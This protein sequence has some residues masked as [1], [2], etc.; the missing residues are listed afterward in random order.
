M[1][2]FCGWVGFGAQPEVADLW[3]ARMVRSLGGQEGS[4]ATTFRS[5]SSALAFAPLAGRIPIAQQGD[6]VAVVEGRPYFDDPELQRYANDNGPGAALIRCFR[7]CGPKA[8]DGMH[9]G[10]SFG[11]IRQGTGEA[12]LAND[13]IGGRFPVYYLLDGP[14]LVF[15][16][17]ADAIRLHPATKPELDPQGIYNYLYFHMVPGPGSAWREIQRLM[18][19]SYLHLVD[20]QATV[21]RYW[22][23]RYEEHGSPAFDEL[24]AEFRER[25]GRSV[26]RAVAG[27]RVG[28]FLSGGT[29]SSTIVGLVGQA[30]GVPAATY[31]IGFGAE[32]YDEMRYARIAAQHFGARHHEY[33]LK[34]D[35]VVALV[36]KIAQAYSEPFGNESAV[37][38]FQCA[39]MGREDGVERMLGGDGGDELFAGN[40]RYAKQW[41]FSLYERLPPRVRQ[42]LLEPIV[43][44]FPAGERIMPLRKAR[45]YIRQAKIRMPDRTQTYGYLQFFG[46]ENVIEPE[47]LA[48]VDTTQPLTLLR[49]SYDGARAENLLNRSLA[50]DLRFTLADNDLPKVSRMCELAGVP[51]EYPFLDDEVLEL[52]CRVPPGLKMKGPRLRW[53]FKRALRDLLPQEIL[54]K[55]KH[56][57]GV[58]F[59]LWLRQD[60][61]LRD[62][63]FDSLEGLGRRRIVRREF[64]DSLSALH[65]TDHA[66]YHGV[67]IWVLMMLEQWFRRNE[68][69]AHGS[70][71]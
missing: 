39:R 54:R 10:F 34:P 67:L 26:G 52:S 65:R 40:S 43:F 18:P 3:L 21:K 16:S 47:F 70:A 25:L 71:P 63:T 64:I 68:A 66:V 45:S 9:G 2:G 29:D 61:P 7:D 8:L 58:P 27:A 14:R 44:G 38:A 36:P 1:S 11:L 56:G 35:D 42:T 33:Y 62:L 6:L 4:T 37:A 20:G 53:F 69:R 60:G 22:E 55:K 24:A 46:V 31:S 41:V 49:E 57:M 50:M 30:S 51:V 19:G 32:G 17:R 5:G 48:T 12:W 23:P 13:R 28:C 59:G 15:A